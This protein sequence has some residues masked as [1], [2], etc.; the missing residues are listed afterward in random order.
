MIS[1][2]LVD[3]CVILDVMTEDSVWFDLSSQM[4][5]K[6]AEHGQLFINPIL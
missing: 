5:A 6:H 1:G 2:I 3:S 4:L